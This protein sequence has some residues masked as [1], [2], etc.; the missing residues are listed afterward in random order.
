[1]EGPGD[2]GSNP[3]TST[4]QARTRG[5]PYP[6]P[7]VVVPKGATRAVRL[8]PPLGDRPTS[9]RS[10]LPKPPAVRLDRRSTVSDPLARVNDGSPVHRGRQ[11]P[12]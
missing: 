1:M 9:T 3:S 11:A 2:E 5:D 7:R 4:K 10:L 8:A 6:G 12:K